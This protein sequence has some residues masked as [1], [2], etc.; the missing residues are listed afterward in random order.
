M[1]VFDNLE[2]GLKSLM[3]KEHDSVI[4]Y[5]NIPSNYKEKRYKQN[6][7]KPYMWSLH[8]GERENLFYEN[9]ASSL[10]ELLSA[11]P[12]FDKA[13]LE[14]IPDVEAFLLNEVKGN[15]LRIYYDYENEDNY[16]YLN[17]LFSM[18]SDKSEGMLWGMYI[19]L[20]HQ[21]NNGLSSHGLSLE[22]AIDNMGMVSWNRFYQTML[23]EETLPEK[24]N[25]QKRLKI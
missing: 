24:S 12:V 21:N 11:L 3:T 5:Y 4:I 25:A 13:T 8:V 16:S 19:Y 9:N 15:G 6:I 17:K 7:E 23:L 22:N 20:E 18:R 2:E 10:L 1:K 14:K